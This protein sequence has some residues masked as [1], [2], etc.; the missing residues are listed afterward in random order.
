MTIERVVATIVCIAAL[1]AGP[2]SADTLSSSKLSIHSGLGSNSWN[3]VKGARPRLIK[4]LDVTGNKPSLVKA[5]VPGIVI[6]GRLYQQ[7]VRM[8]R[9]RHVG[10]S[11]CLFCVPLTVDHRRDQQPTNGDPAQVCGRDGR[12]G[13]WSALGAAQLHPCPILAATACT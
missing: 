6:V 1:A 9:L 10:A 7:N 4:L 3:F 12:G 13:R 11:V 5:A 8:S 2:C